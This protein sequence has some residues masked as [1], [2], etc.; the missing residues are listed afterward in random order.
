MFRLNPRNKKT[1]QVRRG[2]KWVKKQKTKSAKNAHIALGI[3][4]K[5]HKKH[6]R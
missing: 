3:L 2:K 5:W 1:V 4:N 6:K